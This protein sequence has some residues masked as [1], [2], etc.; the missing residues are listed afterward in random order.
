MRL[1]KVI[2]LMLMTLTLPVSIGCGGKERGR[3]PFTPLRGEY[4]D[5]PVEMPSFVYQGFARSHSTRIFWK[6]RNVSSTTVSF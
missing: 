1:A 5:L 3:E 4:S 2:P 6:S